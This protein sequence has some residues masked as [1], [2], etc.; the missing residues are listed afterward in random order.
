MDKKILTIAVVAVVVIAAAAVAVMLMN[1]GSKDPEVTGLSVV[2]RVNS[3]GSGILLAKDVNPEDFITAEVE[4]PGL[5]AI[6]IY[7][8][9]TK[10][11]YVFHPGSWGG[12]IFAT[13]G[14]ATIQHVQLMELASMMNL[15]FVSYT[16]GMTTQSDSLYYIAG[17][18]SFS[19]FENK[20]K[21]A[22]LTGFIIWE[23][24]VSVGAVKGYPVLAKTNELFNDHTCCIIGASNKFLDKGDNIM[25]VFFSVYSKAVDRINAALQ[26]P[27]SEDYLRLVEIATQRVSMPDDMTETEKMTA[28]VSALLNVTYVYADDKDGSLNLLENDIASLAESLYLAKQIE[29]SAADLG[30]KSYKEL[31]EKFVD[32]SYLRKAVSGDFIPLLDKRTINVAAIAGDVHQIAL[33][34]AIDTGMFQGAN[35]NINV[36]S[37]SAGPAVYGLL[38]NGEADIGFLGAPPMTIRSMN[39]GD[40][41]A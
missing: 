6:Y 34:F 19:E 17:V 20:L 7:N 4:Q 30:F 38:A 8:D 37:Q 22:P 29:K 33:W 21:T 24:Q 15:K 5:G 25:A 2:G 41:H 36:Y 27:N 9:E 26:D 18:P 10:L 16:D 31:A 40:I 14:A 11:Y 3:E 39:A 35:L 23:A 32:D 28:I 12:K 1:N 13:P